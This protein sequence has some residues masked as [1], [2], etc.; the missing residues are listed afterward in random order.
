MVGIDAPGIVAT[1]VEE[2]LQPFVPD[3]LDQFPLFLLTTPVVY[4]NIACCARCKNMPHFLKKLYLAIVILT[5]VR[6]AIGW[7]DQ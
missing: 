2:F 3:A 1:A 6:M 4:K 7:T 5:M